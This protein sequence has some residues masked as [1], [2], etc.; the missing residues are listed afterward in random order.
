MQPNRRLSGSA[1][2]AASVRRKRGRA[3]RTCSVWPSWQHSAGR[4]LSRCL[5]CRILQIAAFRASSAQPLQALYDAANL[6][7]HRHSRAKSFPFASCRPNVALGDEWIGTVLKWGEGHRACVSAYL[8]PG[9]G[10]DR[11]PHA[12]PGIEE[13]AAQHLGERLAI[14]CF[15]RDDHFLV[16]SHGGSPFFHAFVTDEAYSL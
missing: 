16:L 13:M 12:L 6:A 8:S 9:F 1:A 3:S 10:S 5:P 7:G 2:I 4:S 11:I 15:E 14:T